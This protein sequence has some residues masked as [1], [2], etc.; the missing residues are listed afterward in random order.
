MLDA[1]SASDFIAK[2]TSLSMDKIN[3]LKNKQ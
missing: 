2:V 3:K 1:D